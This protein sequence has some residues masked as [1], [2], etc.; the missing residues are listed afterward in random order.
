MRLRPWLAWI[1]LALTPMVWAG[2][3]QHQIQVQQ[4]VTTQV[5]TSCRILSVDALD[6]GGTY[7]PVRNPAGSSVTHQGNVK[8]SCTAGVTGWIGANSGSNAPAGLVSPCTNPSRRLVSGA[9]IYLDY[10]LTY[11]Q[12]GAP[13]AWGCD[14]STAPSFTSVSMYTPIIVPTLATIPGGQDVPP[15]NYDDAMV[16]SVNF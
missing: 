10:Q 8:L 9:G 13:M 6:F 1:G 11:D 5:V 16:L 15:G 14:A 12:G 7:D 3:G 4:A 2:A